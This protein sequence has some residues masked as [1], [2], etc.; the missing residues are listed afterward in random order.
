MCNIWCKKFI[1]LFIS[2]SN[3]TAALLIGHGRSSLVGRKNLD[4]RGRPGTLHRGASCQFPFRWIYYRYRT[5][6]PYK[7]APRPTFLR[8]TQRS[9]IQKLGCFWMPQKIL[10]TSE[11]VKKKWPKLHLLRIFFPKKWWSFGHF[12]C[13]F[14]NPNNFF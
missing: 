9:R 7:P 8:H 3:S 4:G 12:F 6:F 1:G 5:L 2:N 10:R 13:M 11:A 14:L